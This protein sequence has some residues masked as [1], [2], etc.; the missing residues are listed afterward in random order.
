[1][2]GIPVGGRRAGRGG[3][4]MGPGSGAPQAGAAAGR[5]GAGGGMFGGSGSPLPDQDVNL[6]SANWPSGNL[7]ARMSNYLCQAQQKWTL[8][9]VPN[10]GGYP[11]SPYFRI[12]VAGTER[13][14]AATEEGE[15]VVLPTFSGGPEQLWRLDQLADGS[16]RIMPKAVPNAK[17]P[18]ALSAI[19]ASSATLST[20]DPAGNKHRWLLKRP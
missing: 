8:K 12:T 5:G 15:L 2:E 4:G 3:A 13:T 9:A 14:L 17:A 6:V 18:M 1:V 20:Y 11:G 19:G 10:G 16:W 7:D